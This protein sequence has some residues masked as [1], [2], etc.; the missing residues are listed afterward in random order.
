[1]TMPTVDRAHHSLRVGQRCIHDFLVDQC[2]ECRP[3]PAGLS[4][5]VFVAS[6]GQVFHRTR[7]CRA[8]LD[9]QAKARHF[10]HSPRDA[11]RSPLNQ[12][13]ARGLSP[14]MVC[15]ACAYPR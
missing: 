2:A 13:R 8:L 4:A 3:V 6:A 11:A 12:A 7:D 10:G 9:G 1:M 15:F 14:C 5:T